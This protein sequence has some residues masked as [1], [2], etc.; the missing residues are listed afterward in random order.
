MPFLA[1]AARQTDAAPLLRI[2]KPTYVVVD[3][4][5]NEITSGGDA[6]ADQLRQRLSPSLQSQ[7][8]GTFE[9]TKSKRNRNFLMV[10][11]IMGAP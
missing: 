10:I 7:A 6:E 8:Q 1:L 3:G 2:A 4:E 5:R 11:F 9:R